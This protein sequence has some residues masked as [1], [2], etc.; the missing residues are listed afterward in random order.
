MSKVLIAYILDSFGRT[1]VYQGRLYFSSK[2]MYLLIK[3]ILNQVH[4]DQKLVHV[5]FLEIAFVC[6]VCMCVCPPP[7]LLITSG[8]ICCDMEPLWLVK[9][10]LGFS[11]SFIWQLKSWWIHIDSRCGLC[12]Q[13]ASWKLHVRRKVRP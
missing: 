7:R 1:C 9:Q 2:C 8:V 5:W 12:K 11:L 6:N 4:T 3:K 13:N 10:V